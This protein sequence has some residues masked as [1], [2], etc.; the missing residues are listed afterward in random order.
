MR[1]NELIRGLQGVKT[2]PLIFTFRA[3][4][5]TRQVG[6]NGKKKEVI[7]IG[8][9]PVTALRSCT[10]L[11]SRASCRRAPRACRCGSRQG[12]RGFHHQA[13]RVSQAVHSRQSATQR[14]HGP[15]VRGVGDGAADRCITPATRPRRSP[16]TTR[17]RSSRPAERAAT[18][19]VEA[20][21]EWWLNLSSATQT[22]L[23][24]E[25]N[26]TLKPQAIAAPT[27][28]QNGSFSDVERS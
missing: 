3:R 12:G 25:K 13:A 5:K 6:G 7:N 22:R 19:G 9:Q 4:E 23:E 8:W 17:T 10:G 27:P 24:R 2:P 15:R 11:T 18:N 16:A 21:K 20:L 28:A 14:G 26:E 1:G